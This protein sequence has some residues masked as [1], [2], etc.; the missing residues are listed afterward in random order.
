MPRQS[1][2]AA[3]YVA[4]PQHKTL[5]TEQLANG[6]PNGQPVAK[7]PYGFKVAMAIHSAEMNCAVEL[8]LDLC[9]HADHVVC[10]Y[11]T[12]RA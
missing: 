4:A 7:L 1:G 5:A 3:K 10:S 6:V 9:G 2:I 12:E 11:G 8:P